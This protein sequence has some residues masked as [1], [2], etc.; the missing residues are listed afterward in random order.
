MSVTSGFFDSSGGDRKYNTEQLSSIFDGILK[1]GVYLSILNQFKVTPNVGMQISVDTGR[2]WFDHT[3]TL[4]DA[5]MNLTVDTAEILQDRIDAVV[6]EVDRSRSVR[7]NSIKMVK[8][9]PSSS[10][11]NPSLTKSEFINQ[12][13]LAYIRV[14]KGATSIGTADITITVGTD[15][16]PFATSFLEAVSVTQLYEQWEADYS[17]WRSEQQESFEEWFANAKGQLTEDPAGN[18]Q[19]Q[20]D[21]IMAGSKTP[22]TGISVCTH[23]KSGTIHKLTGTGTG[24]N[25]RFVATSDFSEG[26]TFQVNGTTCTARTVAGDSLWA[27]FFKS[28]SVV[29]CYRNGD[30]LTFNSGGLPSTEAAKLT[31][32]NLKNGIEIKVN[33]KTISGTF[34]SDGTAEASDIA[35]GKIGYSK[36]NRY[37]GTFTSDANAVASSIRSGFSAYA[38]GKKIS[39]N[40]PNKGAATITPKAYDQS[41]SSGQYLTGNQTI[42]G[43]ANLAS[44]NIR[45]GV[46]IFGITGS[47][48][49]SVSGTLVWCGYGETQN[50]S[51]QDVPINGAIL[52]GSPFF[53]ASGNTAMVCSKKCTIA[54]SFDYW[55]STEVGFS[56]T[57]AI[58]KNGQQIATVYADNNQSDKRRFTS[59]SIGMNPGDRITMRTIGQNASFRKDGCFAYIT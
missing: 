23:A 22:A 55:R 14:V 8:G 47:F 49:D 3:W 27:A 26:D 38:N 51:G 10:P 40:I 9:T 45:Q 54:I 16:C 4:N 28:G 41:I 19:S 33:G 13:P 1:D 39:G 59:G 36:G 2:A 32:E 42:K 50:E 20:I 44:Q 24:D 37:V 17:N 31:P 12:Y 53:Y 30:T 18:L 5:K 43:D 52:Q 34:T 25:I 15:E 7:K 6:L 48:S 21:E 29:T 56:A 58:Y 11:Q 35:P 46:T 57:L